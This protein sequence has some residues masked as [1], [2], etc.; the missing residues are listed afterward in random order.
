MQRYSPVRRTSHLPGAST[1][2][3]PF[4]VTTEIVRRLVPR[5]YEVE[6]A[7][8][9]ERTRLSFVGGIKHMPI[10]YQLRGWG[11]SLT[12]RVQIHH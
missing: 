11:S 2:P 8:P 5:L 6:L 9:V 12:G 10:R 4:S 3:P 1:R 7:G